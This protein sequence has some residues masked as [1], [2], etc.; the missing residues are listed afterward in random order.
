M[1]PVQFFAN[2]KLAAR[3]ALG[4]GT[5]ALGLVV[6]AVFAG[7][8]L[9]RAGD[10]VDHLAGR[11]LLASDLAGRVVTRSAATGHLVAQHLYV[12]DGDLGREDAIQ[13]RVLA[14]RAANDRDGKELQTLLAGSPA[15]GAVARFA[16]ARGT[17]RSLY[18]EALRRSRAETVSKDDE[19]DGSRGLYELRVMP[20]ADRVV[21]A[22]TVLQDDVR[23][24]ARASARETGKAIA[25]DRRTLILIALLALAAAVA[26]AVWITRSVTRPV[27]ELSERMKML[28]GHCLSGLATGLELAAEGDLT[29]DVQPRTPPMTLDTQDEL[30]QLAQTFNAM[31][32][33]AARALA[34]YSSMRAELGGLIGEVSRGAGSV[35][36]ASQ[37]MASTSDEAGRAVGEIAHAVGDVAQGAERQVRMVES[38]RAAVQEAARAAALSSETAGATAEAAEQ[39]RQA[40]LEG[41]DAAAQATDAIRHVAESSAQVATAIEDLAARSERIGGIVTTITGIAEQTN[42]LALNAAIEAARA[43]EQGRG[44]AVVAEEVRKLAEESQGAAAEIAT[45]IQEIQAQTREVVDVVADGA[46]RTEEGVATVEKTRDAFQRI[47]HAIE[48]V[49][50]RIGEIAAAVDQ[51]AGEAQRAEGDI[52]EVASVAEQS[53][54]SAEQVS[55]S[56]EQTSA[57][58][59]EI[60]SSAAEL[61]RTAEDLDRLVGRFRLTA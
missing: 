57:S 41:V 50:V 44:F 51:I 29:H 54:A 14:L 48:G 46:Q 12:F 18:L 7:A 4:F 5:V 32:A 38:T 15:A 8:N 6:V 34:G 19:R 37:Q 33:K 26:L 36:A 58:T 16:A 21:A 22:G 47:D 30:G 24:M 56:T 20:A 55:A 10:D 13:R 40:A 45:L 59:Q 9:N 61:A 3:L 27:H 60:A 17:F 1:S 28:D 23:A 31:L 11:D 25:G 2:L 39:A 42:L 49:G 52:G 53:S 43:G 35:S